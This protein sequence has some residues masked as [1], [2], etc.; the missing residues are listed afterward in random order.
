[1]LGLLIGVTAWQVGDQFGTVADRRQLA[2]QMELLPQIFHG[3][4]GAPVNIDTLPGFI[5]WRLMGIVPLMV[6]LWSAVALAGTIAGE[7]SRGTLEV[8]LSMPVSR[9]RLA[10]QKYAAHAVAM[11]LAL[12][13]AAVLTWLSSVTFAALPG[14][15]MDFAT[16]LAGFSLTLAVALLGG[17]IAFALGPIVGRG[18]A[19]GAAAVYLFGSYIVNGY[20]EMVPGFDVLRLGSVFHW[21]AGHR[22]MAGLYDWPPVIA[23]VAAAVGLAL[24]GAWLFRRRDLAGFVS[25]PVPA[26][27]AGGGALLGRWTLGGPT[28]RSL[29]E[30][31]P[32]ALGWG[33][34]IGAYGMFIALAADEFARTLD[35]VPQIREMISQF[36]P[37]LD[38]S[39]GA[40]MLQLV[41]F[42]FMPLVVGLAGAA[43]AHGWAADERDGRLEIILAA[44]IRRLAWA[45]RSGAGA[46]GAAFLVGLLVGLLM[47][48][49]AAIAGNEPVPVFT[50][51]VVIGLYGSAIAGVGLA[52]GGLLRPAWAGPAAGGLVVG[53]Y[54]L[55]LLGAI[56]G[57]PDWLADLSLVRHLGQPIAGVLNWPGMALCIGLAVGGLVVA[58]AGM[59]RR[60]LRSGT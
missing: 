7:A 1:V 51:G 22:P 20:G 10:A 45:L 23:V 15:E 37:E 39:T 21:T 6:G 18:L 32:A 27:L 60:D 38:F 43:I 3:L 24:V 4:L 36:Y 53:F 28:R 31:L 49:G 57:V 35:A 42:A 5:S 54:L 50:G 12:V 33:G 19:A 47:G 44:P 17:G 16:A 8:V 48:A 55:D 58:A 34:A 9:L 14:D 26:R 30:R 41:V 46:L 40:G 11:V 29:G 56:L 25:L 59:A 13:V 52:V 2:A